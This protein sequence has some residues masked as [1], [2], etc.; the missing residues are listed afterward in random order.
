MNGR[1]CKFAHSAI[2]LDL[3]DGEKKIKNL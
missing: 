2:E 3:V 1:N